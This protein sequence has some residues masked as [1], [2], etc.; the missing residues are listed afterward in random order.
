MEAQPA[1][2][3]GALKRE[4]AA[5]ALAMGSGV[6]LGTV[7]KLARRRQNGRAAAVWGSERHGAVLR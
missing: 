3:A 1:E 7:E 5:V 4:G 2:V 6:P